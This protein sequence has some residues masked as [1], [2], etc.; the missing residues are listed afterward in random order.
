MKIKYL[1]GFFLLLIISC[2]DSNN[3]LKNIGERITITEGL[4]SFHTLEINSI[5]DVTIV[6]SALYTISIEGYSNVMDLIDHKVENG[7]LILK[8]N[9][10]CTW[11]KKEDCPKIIITAPK[12]DT[13]YVNQACDFRTEGTLN[14]SDF[15]FFCFAKILNCDISLNCNNVW[16]LAVATSGR[17]TIK[18]KA[19]WVY[20]QNCGNGV[21]Q[22]DDFECWHL[23]LQHR[24]IGESRIYCTGELNLVEIKHAYVYLFTPI[25][26]QITFKN[27]ED[28]K[29]FF[30]ENC[31]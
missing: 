22:A 11:L 23:D 18:G 19:N 6:D 13:V 27:E 17:Y 8:N 31:I 28:K 3:C 15:N 9:Y 29:L 25:C 14:Y 30:T 1:L 26:P 7:K 21:L 16:F 12:I 10:E 24:S 2:S 4:Q 20:M 5:F